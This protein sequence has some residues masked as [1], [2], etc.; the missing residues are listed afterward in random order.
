LL[1]EDVVVVLEE[2]NLFPLLVEKCILVN[3][4]TVEQLIVVVE[5]IFQRDV[6][7]SVDADNTSERAHNY[8]INFMVFEE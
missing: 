8:L 4:H 5:N 7:G 6:S 1:K 2:I 3:V